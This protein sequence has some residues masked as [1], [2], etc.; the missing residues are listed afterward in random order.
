MA[1]ELRNYITDCPGALIDAINA[2]AGISVD[3]I[4]ILQGLTSA[5]ILD[6]T[7]QTDPGGSPPTSVFEFVSA[8]TGP[9]ETA[10]DNLLS[11]FVCPAEETETGDGTLDDDNGPSD[12]IIWSS[13]KITDDFVNVPG[14]TMTGDLILG[15]SPPAN[16]TVGGM[17]S[18]GD[19]RIRHD[20][21]STSDLIIDANG[22]SGATSAS[23]SRDGTSG[24]LWLFPNSETVQ[25]I[26]G[27]PA[28]TSGDN[29]F[30]IDVDMQGEFFINTLPGAGRTADVTITYDAVLLPGNDGTSDLGST[31]Q[32]WQN[33]YSDGADIDGNITITGN[34]DGV[35]VGTPKNSIEVNTNQYQLVNDTLSPGNTKLYGTNGAGVKGWYD[36][37]TG[38]GG[39]SVQLKWQYDSATGASDPG[40]GK[41]RTNNA[42]IAS[43]TAIYVNEED[44]DGVDATTLLTALQEGDRIFIQQEDDASRFLLLDV[45]TVTDNGSWFTIAYTVDDSGTNFDDGEKYGWVLIYSAN[46]VSPGGLNTHVQY[47][48]NDSFG[49]EENF[50]YDSAIK[51]VAIEGVV[52][53]TML[54]VGGV[55]QGSPLS[56]TGDA[57]VYIEVNT[58]GAGIEGQRV[59]FNRQSAG[60][61]GWIVYFYDGNTPNIRILDED[62]DPPY[63]AFQTIGSGTFSSP[64]FDNQF[65]SRGPVAGATTGFKWTVDGTEIMSVD[66]NF[67]ELPDDT[68]ANRPGSPVNGMVRYNTTTDKFEGYENGGWKNLIQPQKVVFSACSLESPVNADWAVNALAPATPDSNNAGLTVRR[69]DDTTD[70]GVGFTVEIPSGTTSLTFR[71]RSRAETAPGGTVTAS[72]DLYRRSLPDNGAVGAWSSALALTDISLPTNENWQYDEQTITLATLGL[73]AGEIAQFELVRDGGTLSGDWTLLR[74]EVEF[75]G[76]I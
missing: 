70:E 65:G 72:L 66:T 34:V 25:W 9:Q 13:N 36:Q 15:G 40:G 28:A 32:R 21:L 74:L 38:G 30:F 57:T 2:D 10:F 27:D 7:G 26:A 44:E 43:S 64:E 17:T 33:L 24:F 23:I 12:D 41:F 54:K 51:C 42:T 22:R 76:E 46:D 31:S 8:L 35:D 62:D 1:F 71:F 14:D 50:R 61:N 59:Y 49:G 19:L 73:T 45:D 75:I 3:C 6:L 60:I 48:D 11:T 67:L 52:E 47:N 69:F 55:T 39:A 63:I 5:E 4:Q 56:D 18:T 37:P 16:L 58:S 68:T 53:N 20:T 29:R